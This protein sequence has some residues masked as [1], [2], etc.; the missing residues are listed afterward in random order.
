[1][2]GSNDLLNMLTGVDREAGPTPAIHAAEA[3]LFPV[4]AQVACAAA[5]ARRQVLG[6]GADAARGSTARTLR[7]LG[8]AGVVVPLRAVSPV[9]RALVSRDLD[10]PDDET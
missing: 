10:M 2:F 3:A 7:D 6:P 8:F 9:R 1:M 5:R 4:Y